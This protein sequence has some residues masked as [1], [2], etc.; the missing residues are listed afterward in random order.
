MTATL[1]IPGEFH[2]VAIHRTT[3]LAYLVNQA[4]G[5]GEV[6][7]LDLAT[8]AVT[9]TIA[10]AKDAESIV[11]DEALDLA[12]VAIEDK[13][14][15]QVIDLKTNAITATHTLT[16]HPRRMALNPMTHTVVVT[17][18]DSDQ[19]A[20]LD[21]TTQTLT[22]NFA[23]LDKPLAVAA[24]TRYN[25]AL[26]VAA[27][28][29]EIVFIQ[30]PNPA[31]VLTEIVPPD[32]TAPSPAVALLAIGKNFIDA[33][34]GCAPAATGC[35]GSKV[36]LDNNPLTTR[37]K[38]TE[39]L[40]ADVPP[41]VLKTAGIYRIK[42][43]NPAPGGGES[44][45]LDFTVQNPVPVLST[46]SPTELIAGNTN[47][48]LTVSGSR[49]VPTAVVRA[50]TLDL[51]T[52]YTDATRLTAILPG[53]ATANPGTLPITVYNPIPG[54]GSSNAINLTVLPAG[55]KVDSITPNQ[56][57]P[58]TLITLTGSGF[59]PIAP[60]NQVVFAGNVTATVQTATTTEL[61]LTVPPGA[62]T[63]PIQVTT[64][65]GTTQSPSFTVKLPEDFQLVAS[66]ATVT[67]IQNAQNSFAVQLTST[68]TQAFTSLVKLTAQG[69]PTGV[70]AQFSPSAITA[71]QTVKLTLSASGIATP[72]TFNFTVTGTATL[73]G[74]ETTR[75]AT[76]TVSLQQ[77]GQ[78]GVKGRF[79][80]P[81]GNGIA[82]V[83]VRYETLETTSDA[84]GN[85]LLLGLPA[86]KVTLRMDAT[87]ANSLYPIWPLTIDTQANQVTV[88]PDWVIN[89]PPPDQQFVAINNVV[90]DQQVTDERYPGFSLTLPKG[91]D[92]IGWDGVKK[93]RIAV[94]RYDMNRL[95]VTPPPVP[96]KEA[97]QFFFGTPMGGIP[98]APIPVTLPNVAGLEPG[99]KS[100]IWY[101]DGSPM[102]GSGEWK[103]AGPGTISADGKTVTTDPG[104]GI[105][106]FCGV[107]GWSI[108][109]CKPIPGGINGGG[110]GDGGCDG[111]SACCN[112][113]A[114]GGKGG[115]GA[116]G[117]GT[118]G[119]GGITAGNP[120]DLYS[121][122][123]LTR[124]SDLSCNGL[125]PLGLGRVYNPVDAFQ[126]R[127]GT[128]GSL[129]FGW[130]LNYDI[131]L[132]PF[133]GSQKRLVLAGNVPINF[134][135]QADG[136]YTSTEDLRVDGAVLK[137]T[138]ATAHEWE[139]RFKDGKLWKF[140]PFPGVPGLIRGGPPT[141]LTE[142]VDPQGNSLY[143]SRANN[144]HILS[145]GTPQR[146]MKMT[147]G[148]NNFI[149]KIE[150]PINR[151]LE[152]TYNTDNR[153]E[154][155]KDPSGG[156]TRYTYVGDDE[157]PVSSVCP[158][159]TTGQRIKTITYPGVATP[160][161]NHHG[162]SRRILRQTSSLGEYQFA[163]KVIGACVTN[164]NNPTQRCTTNCPDV[165][166]WENH[167]AGWRI[168]GGE[169]VAT[170]VTDPSG[171]AT[172][173]R[174]NANGVV[175]ESQ[176]SLAGKTI[177][178][179]DANN[180]LI[181]TTDA[182]GRVTKYGYDDRGN[183]IRVI[184]P[185]NRVTD[186]EYD[187]KWN[188]VTQVLRYKED[189]STVIL[190][191]QTYDPNT[192]NL[193]S[194][195]DANGNRT[196]YTYTAKKQ[197]QTITD[198]KGKITKLAYNEA[199]DLL[200]I[201][202]PLGHTVYQTPDA[203]GRLIETTDALGYS[204]QF[205]LNARDQQTQ[206]TDATGNTVKLAYDI[207]G[208][209]TSVTNQNN[210]VI[211]SS[212]YD[213]EDRL[214]TRTDGNN[215]TETF[216]YD[217]NG[218][219]K[220]HTDRKGQT[221]TYRY[222]TNNRMQ[223]IT[224]SDGGRQTYTYDALGRLVAIADSQGTISYQYDNL[225]RIVQVTTPQGTLK[226]TYDILNRRTQLQTPQQTITYGH[227]PNG[228]LTRITYGQETVTIAYDENNRR[229]SLI[230]PNGIVATYSYDDAGRT[231]GIA[232]TNGTTVIESMGYVYDGNGNIIQRTRAGA[233]S[234]QESPKNAAY[235]PK[236]NRLV[237]FNGETFQYDENGNLTTRTNSCGATSYV[238]DSRNRLVGIQGYKPDCASL[239]ASF[240]YD[241]LG[242][243]TQTTINNQ[244]TTYLYDG[245]DVIAEMGQ[246][247]AQYLRTD[248]IDDAI[249]R[250]TSQGDRYLLTDLLGSTLMLT[251]DQA[252]PTTT[253][254][255]SPYGE[256]AVQ[257]E[258]TSN[259]VQYTG[260][261]NDGTGFYYYRAR[262]YAPGMARFVARDPL[263]LEAGLNEFSY[264][265]NNPLRYTD[266][267][268][269]QE[270]GSSGLFP[271]PGACSYYEK[272]CNETCGEDKYACQA[273]KCCESFG[274]NFFSNC[275]RKCLIDQDTAACSKLSGA[276]RD[277][278]RKRA[279]YFCYTV[280]LNVPDAVSGGFGTMP[281]PA[282]RGAADAI[283]GMW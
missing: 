236:T 35:T 187:L 63:G 254:S 166:S 93:T 115:A 132:L 127:A 258:P 54:G 281:P 229:K 118:N 179:Y 10:V 4:K 280:C 160:T 42:I 9:G 47:R 190:S 144:G 247:P 112:N 84:A 13:N 65:K 138:N 104:Y 117:G 270:S 176:D 24:T 241:A 49:F 251:N 86:G 262:Y 244:T 3:G 76:A 172:I 248:N 193:T 61:K 108:Q 122:H 71:N 228:S 20:L 69:L 209:L 32:V 263:G 99:E 146:A 102:G 5:T 74:R 37:W 105:P 38:D 124:V 249:A 16:K 268:G 272:Q 218:N 123:E 90:Q 165:D 151:S 52:T 22:P 48:T 36:Y 243:R 207:R 233:G 125:V 232:Y 41:D 231:T 141:F 92:I 265:R 130:T 95:P 194:R 134:T 277:S 133:T 259:P 182:L 55:P 145:V 53:S 150:D 101:Y 19:I 183:K 196:T 83:Y 82:G 227:D 129:G 45:T 159:P 39:H 119:G 116:G 174:F 191:Q 43:I 85:F 136:T 79:V 253:Y 200:S 234:K 250:Y 156:I 246:N 226:Y 51:A 111:A 89:P 180:R 274:D 257:G 173:N 103:L 222:D 267:M 211:E 275:T 107:C 68:G 278:C 161:E 242:R 181:Q 147:Y 59:D 12:V 126:N 96:A 106:R 167:Q 216:T 206:I 139:L 186:Y 202:D 261:E 21:L 282:C 110:N 120:V 91:V 223:E 170:T 100:D 6:V 240:Q 198:A 149:S 212:T 73:N 58:G 72:T 204:T 230:Y 60:Q 245:L 221:T 157:Y 26:V 171:N 97:Y 264:V 255:Y 137:A 121:G 70:S 8:R 197:L 62:I 214:L 235:D 168:Y 88:F 15:L 148:A 67:L 33:A 237:S 208:N 23:A 239:T 271:G 135:V 56:G 276:A 80:D 210:Q 225:N 152:F 215:K 153:L 29:G 188:Q 199:G 163:Y 205:N 266:P 94:E 177:N 131:A 238:W 34:P 192:G 203:A 87:P 220:T 178:K 201:T 7:I 17:A 283:G 252:S 11:I 185:D 109:D 2:D 273:K 269:L 98:S 31:P 25:Q 155:V 30:L 57:E 142:I 40:E 217:A 158:I 154:T 128:T 143:I 224:Y 46:V 164:I 189:G 14:Q 260:R 184:E 1:T 219:L 279:H 213:E 256:T 44:Q 114:S 81:N 50:G 78:T 175:T 169:V 66:P 28:Q 195:T 113:G 64:N 77:A 27:E 75:T 140:K 162:V 18:K